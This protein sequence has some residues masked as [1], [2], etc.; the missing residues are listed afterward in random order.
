V[1]GG[2][3][4][5]RIEEKLRKKFFNKINIFNLSFKFRFENKEKKFSNQYCSKKLTKK[6][7]KKKST[8]QKELLSIEP[9][10]LQKSVFFFSPFLKEIH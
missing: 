8:N 5:R 3:F 6:K 7:K 10:N 4:E 2:K 1:D 9:S